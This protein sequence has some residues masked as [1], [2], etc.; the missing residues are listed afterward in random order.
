MSREAPSLPSPVVARLSA[1]FVLTFLKETSAVSDDD[2]ID[3]VI[4]AAMLDAN[5]RHLIHER[6]I[7]LRYASFAQP[8]PDTMRRGASINAIASSLGLPFETTRRRI[9]RMTER[10]LCEETEDGVLLAQAQVTTPEMLKFIERNLGKLK[11]FHDELRRLAP[12]I[13]LVLRDEQSARPPAE[14]PQEVSRLCMRA[15]VGYVLRYLEGAKPIAGDLLGAIVFLAVAVRNVEHLTH[16]ASEAGA[17]GARGGAVPD[18]LRRRATVHGVSKD[19]G[20]SF[21]TTRRRVHKLID[22]GA[23]VRDADGVY[24]PAEVLLSP[25]LVDHRRTNEANL[26]RMFTA[27]WRLGV[28]FD[29]SSADA[30]V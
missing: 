9:H 21:E 20:F 1:E 29:D 18:D 22:R 4:R 17:L 5:I 19:L 26:Q 10:G 8:I 30:R 15:T 2:F 23:L 27:L 3:G 28:R 25:V 7:A 24:V 11:A 12:S 14:P 13:D 6:E 16:A